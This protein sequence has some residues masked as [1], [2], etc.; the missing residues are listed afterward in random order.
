MAKLTK[1]RL[2][3]T[4][5]AEKDTFLWCDATPGFGVRIYPSGK[6]VFIAQVR[7]G[8]SQRRIKIGPYGPWTVEQ[9]R[10][11]ADTIIRN[12]SRGVD[13]Q[14]AKRA[15]RDAMTVSELC[16]E[17]LTAAESGQVLTRF[18]RPKAAGTIALDK[19]RIARHIKPL[20]GRLRACEVTRADVQRMVDSIAAGK[21]AGSFDGKKPRGR[22]RVTGGAGTAARVVEF[23]GGIFSWAEKR[24]YVPEGHQPVRGVERARS[25]PKDRVLSPGELKALGEA[26]RDAERTTPLAAYAIELI[27]L[28][29][30]RRQEAVGL[31]WLEIDELGKCLRLKETKTGRSTRPLGE[32]ALEL[33]RER[34]P[35]TN[36]VY[37]FPRGDGEGPAEIKK[38]IATIFDDAGLTDARSH[39]LR[40]TFASTAAEIGYGDG[41]IG[42]LLGHAARGV[43]GLHYIRRPDRALVAA[44]D[45]TAKLIRLR[46][47]GAKEAE[48]IDAA[49]HGIEFTGASRTPAG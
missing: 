13:P 22:A 46:M 9:A 19:G 42:E 11:E 17:Y 21:T 48:V 47:T 5:P 44:A 18:G 12:A 25:R 29:G 2:D 36:R 34:I 7:V 38:T 40:R 14:A 8:R 26:L 49:R 20:I 41:V 43:T 16:D 37:V 33:L 28:T 39:D 6:A 1:R 23:L 35:K 27:A 4:K 15:L 31:T 30:L 32:P 3:A 24:G 10:E 45:E